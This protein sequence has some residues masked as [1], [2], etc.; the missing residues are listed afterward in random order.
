[1]SLT[2]TTVAAGISVVGEGIGNFKWQDSLLFFVFF[3]FLF[4]RRLFRLFLVN[5][6]SIDEWNFLLVFFRHRLFEDFRDFDTTN[7][8]HRVYL[9]LRDLFYKVWIAFIGFYVNLC[10]KIVP[11]SGS[12]M[13]NSV[14]DVTYCQFWKVILLFTSFQPWYCPFDL[15]CFILQIPHCF[16]QNPWYQF[17]GINIVIKVCK[18]VVLWEI[19]QELWR[20][21][22]FWAAILKFGILLYQ[23][24]KA[25]LRKDAHIY[26]AA[27]SS[28]ICLANGK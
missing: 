9:T 5:R 20:F 16:Y 25:D 1:M 11:D 27:I 6:C 4:F 19:V 24:C 3:V 15:E 12:I 7:D 22:L 13:L 8:L 17:L 10:Y 21:S 2:S 26:L 23:V 14:G 28:L 18:I